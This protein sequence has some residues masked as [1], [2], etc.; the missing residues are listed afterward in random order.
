MHPQLRRLS[1]EGHWDE[2]A[3]LVDDDLLD[4]VVVRGDPDQVARRL[5]ARFAG[6]VD[7]L[8]IYAPGGI[9]DDTL[10]AV[11]SSLRLLGD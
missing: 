9:T 6:H 4:A 2:M 5:H 10:A 11:V 1:R 3:A 8:A 7:R